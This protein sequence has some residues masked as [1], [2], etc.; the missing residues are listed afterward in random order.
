MVTGKS[1]PD[2]H[3]KSRKKKKVLGPK[4]GQKGQKIKTKVRAGRG[5]AGGIEKM[6]QKRA[7]VS[8]ESPCGGFKIYF[9]LGETEL[10][11]RSAT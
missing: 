1:E 9:V 2:G 8:L 10:C 5:D 4:K 11:Q 6:T 3:K 7:A